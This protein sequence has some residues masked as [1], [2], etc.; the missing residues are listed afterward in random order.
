MSDSNVDAQER[1][2]RFGLDRPAAWLKFLEPRAVLETMLL[3]PSA[4]LLGARRSGDGRQIMVLPGFLTD[5]NVTW[6]LRRYLR[7]LG[8]RPQGWQLGRN[9]GYPER[10]A[11]QLAKTLDTVRD[12]DTPITLIGWSLGGVVAREVA[13][14]RPDAVREVITLGAPVEG[15]PKYTIAADRIARRQEMDLDSFEAHVHQ[16]N[17]QG[18]TQPLTVIYSR[19]DGV[20]GWRAAIDR[21]N[22]QARHIRVIGS[23]LGLGTNPVVW[24]AIE[25][26]LRL[27]A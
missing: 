9:A 3:L 21:Y 19:S 23:H 15:G 20:V 14:A 25:K 8:Y 4:P 6:P 26:T 7:Y 1:E 24:R 27:S 2:A 12:D 22:P 5:D 11:A 18:I 17:Q 13:R 10:D 16:I